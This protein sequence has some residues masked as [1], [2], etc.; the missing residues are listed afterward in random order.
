MGTF[1][2]VGE[3]LCGLVFLTN[4]LACYIFH[5][6]MRYYD[7]VWG[8]NEYRE[9]FVLTNKIPTK[10]RLQEALRQLTTA[11]PVEV[12]GYGAVEDNVTRNVV[13]EDNTFDH[14]PTA[15]STTLFYPSVHP[16]QRG[17]PNQNQSYPEPEDETHARHAFPK[18]KSR[19]V[20]LEEEPPTSKQS[21]PQYHQV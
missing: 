21:P 12:T 10:K 11:S 9:Y 14:L 2:V 17:V 4:C 18:V 13:V 19:N 15:P 8:P 20:D 16:D 7:L 3:L 6:R 1:F 5:Q